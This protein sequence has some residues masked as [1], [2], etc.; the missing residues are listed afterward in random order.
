M[1]LRKIVEAKS[2]DQ[3]ADLV[4]EIK[5]KDSKL[6]ELRDSTI[7]NIIQIFKKDSTDELTADNVISWFNESGSF[8]EFVFFY[9]ENVSTYSISDFAE[10]EPR[11]ANA[12]RAVLRKSNIIDDQDRDL[13]LVATYHNDP[14]KIPEGTHKMSIQ[15]MCTVLF[16]QLTETRDPKNPDRVIKQKNSYLDNIA[17]VED[18]YNKMT[19]GFLDNLV[20]NI[21]GVKNLL[22][23]DEAE[24]ASQEEI[25]VE[26]PE[27]EVSTEEP[28]PQI[29]E[30]AFSD[31]INSVVKQEWELISLLNGTIAS[32]N[33]DYK[34]ENKE[35]II[36]I[37]NQIVDDTTIN[38]GM[39]HK[40]NELISTKSASLLNAG[41]EKAEEI[42]SE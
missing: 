35:D 33:F 2:K 32:F 29:Q 13:T 23:S 8:G 31:L 37:L 1:I 3:Y 6:R 20:P 24:K 4:R 18:A 21:P 28:Q 15:E 9:A 12:I 40:A 11:L 16:D 5:Q 27:V 19:E 14:E 7:T 38:I 10:H 39:L 30:T 41:E 36:A 22:A 17:E 34:D 25:N 26:V 42:I